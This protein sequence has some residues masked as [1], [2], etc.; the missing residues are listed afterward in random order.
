MDIWS[1]PVYDAFRASNLEPQP[2]VAKF[3]LEKSLPSCKVTKALVESLERYLL[4]KKDAIQSNLKTPPSREE[5]SISVTDNLGVESVKSVQQLRADRFLDSTTGVVV[6]FEASWYEQQT[7]L[8]VNSRFD[9][10]PYLSKLTIASESD[11]ARELAV[12]IHRSLSDIIETA[13]TSNWRYHP[14]AVIDGALWPL[15]AGFIWIGVALN[16]FVPHAFLVGVTLAVTLVAY[17][18]L[19]KRLHPYTIFD[20]SRAERLQKFGDWFEYGLLAFLVFGSAF[21]FFRKMLFGF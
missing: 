9:K 10:E 7:K 11:A 4:E 6:S 19:G 17:L 14:P 20:S 12:G 5:F 21:P 16:D 15:S 18:T 1:R 3:D 13:K 2:A 8:S